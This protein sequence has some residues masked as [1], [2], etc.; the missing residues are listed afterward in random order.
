M[1]NKKTLLF[2]VLLIFPVLSLS[3]Q[4]ALGIVKL[5]L[6]DSLTKAPIEFATVYVSMDGSTEKAKYSLTDINGAAIIKNVK[7]G[8]Y[9]LKA[10]MM[11]YK[12]FDKVINIKSSNF[13]AGTIVIMPDV[14]TL[15]QATV[16]AVGNPM[17]VK[18]DTIEYNAASYK[19]SDNDMLEDLLKKLPGVEV[20]EDGKITANGKVITKITIDGKTFFL[21]DP[22]LASKNLPAKIINKVKVVNKKSEQAEFTGIDDGEEE[23]IIDLTI[24]PGMMKGWFGNVSAGGGLDTQTSDHDARWQGSAM[25]GR[26]TENNQLAIIANGN[27]TNNRGFMDAA[28]GMLSGGGRGGGMGSQLFIG[29]GLTTSWMGGVNGS[30]YIG[31]NKDRSIG[32]SYMYGGSESVVEQDILK[33]TMLEDGTKLYNDNSNRRI[34]LSENHKFGVDFLYKFTEK[35]SLVFRPW[36]NVGYATRENGSEFLSYKDNDLKVNDGYSK[37]LD[38]SNSMSTGGRLF[39]R[40]RIGEKKGRTISFMANYQFSKNVAD[41]NN[42]SLTN[43]YFYEEEVEKVNK[44]EIDQHYT[45]N[46][47]S[48]SLTGRL[49]YTEPLGKD[50]YIEAAYKASFRENNS[51]KKTYNKDTDDEY[52]IL[53]EDFSNKIHNQ[54]LNHNAQVNLQKQS[55]KYILQIGASIQPS[56]TKSVTHLFAEK[57]DSVLSYSTLNWSPSARFDYK[58]KDGER[59]RLGYWGRTNQPTI[60]QLQP[61]PDNSDPINISLGNPSLQPEFTHSLRA[62][63]SYTNMKNYFSIYTSIEGSYIMDDIVNASWYNSKGVHF[64]APVNAKDGAINA[65]GYVSLNSPI[66]KSNFSINSSTY[67]SVNASSS[68]NGTGEAEDIKD[69]IEHLEEGR[70]TSLR[71]SEK[72]AFKY[73]NKFLEAV[74]GAKASYANAFYT[75]ETNEKPATWTNAVTGSIN[76]T[77]PGGVEIKSDIDYT[78]YIGYEDGYGDPQTVWNAQISKLLFKN[79]AT[80]T[81]KMYDILNQAK[82]VSRITEDN[83]FQD[84]TNNTLGQYIILSFTYRFGDFGN[85]KNMG[86]R[87][88]HGRYRR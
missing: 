86:H 17:I 7:K 48:Y 54:F 84:V 58:I 34:T 49:S 33:T 88:G 26:F 83:Y 56:H 12:T 64:T 63:Y 8:T 20:D 72:L 4:T 85:M 50:F 21:D 61:I 30:T 38:N 3:A 43:Q 40:Q 29:N 66:A 37:A 14:S 42:R 51:D 36:G 55:K 41:G 32:G 45:N 2:L 75:I 57:R 23:P 24:K 5:K 31:G 74:V 10:E 13:D 60:T 52:T 16:S 69:M 53:D 27:N 68:F 39:F 22:T 59:I 9:H 18:Q 11:G 65:G 79:K 76:A 47:D 15:E 73:R 44:K 67:L 35:T 62:G 46:T 81:L 70:T 71:I 28:G 78:F 25:V 82:N 77:I 1:Q 87:G 6:V 19:I 80:L